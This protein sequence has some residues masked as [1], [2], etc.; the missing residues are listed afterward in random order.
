[1][2]FNAVKPGEPIAVWFSCGAASA[3]AA[4]FTVDMFGATNTVRVLNNP[5]AEEH[6]DNQRFR[7][8]VSDWIG[9]DI[10][11][12]VNPDWPAA[13]CKEVWTK[14]RFMAGKDGAPC[15]TELKKRARQKW[16]RHNHIAWHVLGFTYDEQ[17]RHD[18][19]ILTERSNLIP[20]LINRGITKSKCFA[21]LAEANIRL[22]EI[23]DLGYPNANCIGCV[24]ASSPTYWNHVRST[25]P[26]QWAERAIQS[27]EIGARLV[28]YKGK[29]IFLDELPREARGR[30][31]ESVVAPECGIFCEEKP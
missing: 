28:R 29:R 2:D 19:F 22:P 14:R 27:R 7:R 15:T 1:M 31:L 18:R 12:V 17:Q 5:V 20:V 3:V 16:E 8:D 11:T 30:P 6:Y 24:K 9:V 21:I 13:S 23:Y 4:K 26:Y 10:E 25:H